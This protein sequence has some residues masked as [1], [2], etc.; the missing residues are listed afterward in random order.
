MCNGSMQSCYD[1][2][3][4]GLGQNDPRGRTTFGGRNSGFTDMRRRR[5][6]RGIEN[7]NRDVSCVE[8]F[9][10]FNLADCSGKMARCPLGEK[11]FLSL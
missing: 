7:Q 3:G 9:L 2:Q 6:K 10:E 5:R 11:T 8:V 4:G 1:G